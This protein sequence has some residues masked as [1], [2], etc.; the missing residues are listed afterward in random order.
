[1][2]QP[3]TLRPYGFRSCLV[4]IEIRKLISFPGARLMSVVQCKDVEG[5]LWANKI[6]PLLWR[7]KYGQCPLKP[8]DFAGPQLLPM[9]FDKAK[10]MSTFEERRA[11]SR[12]PSIRRITSVS[13]SKDRF[14]CRVLCAVPQTGPSDLPAVR[15][16]LRRPAKE[17][18]LGVTSY[19]PT[20]WNLIRTS[21][22][23]SPLAR[24]RPRTSAPRWPSPGRSSQGRSPGCP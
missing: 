18:W 24:S 19:C 20:T 15:G 13:A 16:D 2:G 1:M 9:S 23:R 6:T 7:K 22:S 12:L 3:D 10:C 14:D 21:S 17:S 11:A 4:P 8:N 5:S